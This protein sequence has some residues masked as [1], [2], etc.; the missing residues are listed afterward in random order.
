M[1][2]NLTL[3]NIEVAGVKIGEVSVSQEYS[4]AEAIGLLTG[5]KKFI[6]EVV[7]ELPEFIDDCKVVADKVQDI[8][9]KNIF[10]SY[11]NEIKK[12]IDCKALESVMDRARKDMNVTDKEYCELGKKA[13]EKHVEIKQKNIDD[14]SF[15]L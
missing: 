1:K 14:F 8:D 5:V 2:T 6:K 11:I 15:F 3:K 10:E 9:S 12:A 13:I 7:K 4:V